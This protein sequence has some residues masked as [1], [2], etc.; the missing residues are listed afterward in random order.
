M[1][2]IDELHFLKISKKT[3]S[4]GQRFYFISFHLSNYLPEATHIN[5]HYSLY[6]NLNVPELIFSRIPWAIFK[7]LVPNVINTMLHTTIQ[8][9][10]TVSLKV[11][12]IFFLKS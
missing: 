4:Y 7:K 12:N 5:Q 1:D 3:H 8:Y 10:N 2:C 9:I 11:L 6:I